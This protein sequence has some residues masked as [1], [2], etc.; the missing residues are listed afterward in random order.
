MSA[1][2]SAHG[3]RTRRHLK[4]ARNAYDTEH[5]VHTFSTGIA[6]SPDLAAARRV[7][8]FLGTQH[9]EFTFTVE[10]GIDAVYDLIYHIESFEQA[11]VM[12]VQAQRVGVWCVTVRL[13]A[14]A[15]STRLSVVYLCL[16]GGLGQGFLPAVS[17]CTLL[18]STEAAPGDHAACA[19]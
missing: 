3:L 16:R 8:Q 6:G 5:G 1:G 11:R 18:A 4:E 9:H 13:R 14:T 10:E 12:G 15:T 17:T 7:A 19:L 2:R